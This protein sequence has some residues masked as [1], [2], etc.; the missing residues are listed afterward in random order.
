MKGRRQSFM[1][2]S[3]LLASKFEKNTQIN[4]KRLN[5]SVNMNLYRD[6]IPNINKDLSQKDLTN[7]NNKSMLISKK[8][9]NIKKFYYIQ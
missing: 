4:S 9:I 7:I 2:K 6:L 5:L 1:P 3:L 8:Q